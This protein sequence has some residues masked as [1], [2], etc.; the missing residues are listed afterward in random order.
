MY[1]I[2]PV[3]LLFILGFLLQR[4]STLTQTSVAGAKRIVSD[5]A[6]PALLFQ[7]FSSLEI[8]SKYLILVVTIFLVCLLMVLLGKALAKPLHMETPYFPLLLGGFEMGMLGYALFLSA[9]GSEHV[10]KMALID[11]GQVLFVFFVLMAF[12]I[13]ERDGAHTTKALLKQF[14]TSPVI[15]AIFGGIVVS[16]I[17]PW[18]S[19]HP[20][21]TAIDEG[22]SLLASLTT[23]LIAL[24]I[25]YGIHI[26]KEGLSWSL[27]TIMVRKLV[28][29]GLALLINHFLI[30][31]LL[32]MDT[33]YRYALLVM[34]LTPPPYVVTIYM[35]PNDPVNAGYV[36]NTLSLDTLVS[37]FLV[38]AAVVLYR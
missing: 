3:L 10:G 31:R 32:G 16:I 26:K 14:I 4:G 1:S 34:F 12:L 18:F 2:L 21:W 24:S 28:L 25:G 29:L 36:D 8:E 30:D 9:Y 33:I 38:M 27:K 11:L 7:A 15:L 6:L 13:R 35:R 19:P 5:L 37:I 20:V 23:P 22:I 17:G